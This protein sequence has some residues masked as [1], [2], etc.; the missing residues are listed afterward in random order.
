MLPARTH[1]MLDQ[2]CVVYSTR[3]RGDDARPRPRSH[4]R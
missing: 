2:L 4:S 1:G 3:R